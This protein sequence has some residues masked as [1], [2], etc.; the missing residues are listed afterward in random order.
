MT[1]LHTCMCIETLLKHPLNDQYNKT[2]MY[3][4]KTLLVTFLSLFGTSTKTSNN[5]FSETTKWIL[6]IFGAK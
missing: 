1:R 6:M 4:D 2:Y 3:E 5:S